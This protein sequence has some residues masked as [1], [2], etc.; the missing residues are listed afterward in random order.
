M[1]NEDTGVETLWNE[2]SVYACFCTGARSFDCD[3]PTPTLEQNCEVEI[4]ITPTSTDT[5][6]FHFSL[7]IDKEKNTSPILLIRLVTNDG[8]GVQ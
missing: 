4:C 2:Y 3:N 6:I 1:D 8:N 5:W 7:N